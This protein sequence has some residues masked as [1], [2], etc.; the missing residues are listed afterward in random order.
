MPPRNLS[1]LSLGDL[2]Q[3]IYQNAAK[4]ASG[5]N[6]TSMEKL[7]DDTIMGYIN[8]ATTRIRSHTGLIVPLYLDEGGLRPLWNL[9]PLFATLLAD[10]RKWTKNKIWA[11]PSQDQ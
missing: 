5:R 2:L 7:A 9:H 3:V 4:F 10:R 6:L 1:T 8:A 11:Y